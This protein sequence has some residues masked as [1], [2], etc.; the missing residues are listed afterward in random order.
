MKTY[1]LVVDGRHFPIADDQELAR[2]KL[3]IVAAVRRSGDFVSLHEA[4][5]RPV[6]VLV[7]TTTRVTVECTPDT[8]SGSPER[9]EAAARGENRDGHEDF[10]RYTVDELSFDADFVF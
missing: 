1:R 8:G 10:S 4:D 7:T 3:L 9:A 6:D 2:V 5:G